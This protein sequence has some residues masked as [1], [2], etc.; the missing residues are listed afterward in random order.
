MVDHSEAMAGVRSGAVV[1]LE[2][3]S[4]PD[5]GNGNVNSG[6]D[7]VLTTIFQ[8]IGAG[9][10]LSALILAACCPMESILRMSGR[11]VRFLVFVV[12]LLVI[13]TGAAIL[14]VAELCIAWLWEK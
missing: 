9:V 1:R 6:G 13:W 12:P 2:A 10:L 5:P 11:R 4:R 3:R 7:A 8:L 14:Y